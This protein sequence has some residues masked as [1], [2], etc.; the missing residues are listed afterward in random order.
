MTE[1][2]DNPYG[3]ILPPERIEAERRRGIWPDRVLTEFLDENAERY[4]ERPAFAGENSTSGETVELGW[5]EL[6]RRAD[7]M[8]LGLHAL[9]VGAGDVVSFQLP[10]WWQFVALHL[11]CV[12]LG[13]VTNPLMPIFRGHELRFMLG[14]AGSKVLIVPSRFRGFDHA[15]MAEELRPELPDLE[16]VLVV[17]GEGERSFE[18]RLLDEGLERRTDAAEVLARPGEPNALCQLLYTSG[19]TGEPKGV[20][21]TANTL[22]AML[23]PFQKA[24]GFHERDVLFMPSP[25]AHQSAFTYGIV[26]SVV[27]GARLVAMDVW[28]PG[29]AAALLARWGATC[30]FAATPFL[31]DLAELPNLGDHDLGAFRLFLTAGAPV[32]PAVAARAAER[33]GAHIATGWGMS[34]NGLVTGTRLEDPI[35]RL[36]ESDGRAH[37]GWEVRVV[38]GAGAPLPPGAEGRLQCRGTSQFVGYFKRPQLY[39]LDQDGWLETGDNARMDGAG[40]IRITGRSKDIIIR[41]GENVPV[42]EVEELAYSHASVLDAALVAMPDKRLGERGC[43]FVT[44]RPGAALTLADLTAHLTDH[45]LAK[46]YFPERLEIIDDFPRTPSGK[47]Q[48]F[49]LREMAEGFGVQP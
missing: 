13:A 28:Q 6:R 48:K 45:Q 29:R 42:A 37:E 8:A 43:L 47:I 10:N 15:A 38:D 22:F 26:N 46:H 44:L 23:L 25:F 21:H 35:E 32:P 16:H 27:L 14:L 19:T 11:A 39:D 12:R 41:G 33:L 2:D 36:L 4:P 17:G 1:S 40:Y 30:M 9:G 3:V 31:S 7:R 34:E 20:M 49:K 18:A 24:Y 5:G